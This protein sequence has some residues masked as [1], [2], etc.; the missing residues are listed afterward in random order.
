MK[1]GNLK[2]TILKMFKSGEFYGYEV[3]KRLASEGLKIEISHLYRIL[4]E[5]LKEGLLESHWKKS[6]L[7]PKKRV[8]QLGEKGREELDK[9]LLDAIETAHYFYGDYL[10]KLSP[11]AN[12]F[13]IICKLLTSNLKE[14]GNIVYITP[15]FSPPLER[16]ARCLHCEVPKAKIYLVKPK[17]LAVNLTQDNLTF[18]DGN[19][20]SIPLR[21]SYAD[22][23][24][25]TNLP[26]KNFFGT[27]LMEWHRV[28]R[29]GGTLAI[30]TP[31][32]QVQKFKDP[33]TIGDY[34]EKYE[35]ETTEGRRYVDK[36]F[37]ETSLKKF[38]RGVEEKQVV[39]VTIFLA[40]SR[41]H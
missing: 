14:E 35:N 2:I 13:N 9:I 3:H 1:T 5:M 33:M 18:L 17:S 38:F 25:V 32:V 40:S 7:G 21:N 12:V 16:I 24:I 41:I 28:L 20:D 10:R 15:R 19:Y 30:V 22:L 31:T 6:Q 36:G 27:S 4:N 37:I 11:E 39:H 8:Y 29:K 34:I 26:K 23:V